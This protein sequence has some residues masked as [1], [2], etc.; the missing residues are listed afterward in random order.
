MPRHRGLSLKRFVFAVPWGLFER[1]FAELKPDARPN[2]WAF[3]NPDMLEDFLGD[4][5]NAEASPAILED[6]H[7]INDLAGTHLGLLIRAYDRSEIE[8]DQDLSP[9][10][11]AMHLFL[12]D[13]KAFEYAWTMYLLWATPSRVYEYSLAAGDLTAD[14]EQMARM[15]ANL[16]GWFSTNKKGTQCEIARFRDSDGLLIR[17]S[18]G[19]YLKTVAR[20]HGNEIAFE[21]FRPAS[22]DIVLYDPALS[23]LKVQCGVRRDRERY[24]RSFAE[25]VAGDPGLGDL[26]LSQKV[27]SLD[28]IQDGS[29]NYGGYGPITRVWL[30]EAHIRLPILGEPIFI[31]R[32]DDVV[33][34]LDESNS[35]FLMKS[36]ELLRVKLRFEMRIEADKRPRPVSFDIEPPGYS[37]LAQRSYARIIDDYLR[38]QGVRL[39]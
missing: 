6:F 7:R 5:A 30:V 39:I 12:D 32:G 37:S 20:W 15:R 19:S 8:C 38:D 36:G 28:P 25:F 35:G 3:L 11:Q 22:E 1:Y 34:A 2:A 21:T 16:Q 13:R 26:A 9:E 10:A 17:I 29:F 31:V 14:E 33:R 4:P 24:L 18:R 27:F 23:V